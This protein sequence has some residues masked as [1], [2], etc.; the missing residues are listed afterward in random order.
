MGTYAQLIAEARAEEREL[1]TV[2]RREDRAVVTLNEPD[3][4][5]PLSLGLTLQLQDR[6]TEL[7][8]DPAIRAVVLT[9]ADPAFCAGGDIGLIAS[10]SAQI[11]D[12]GS[13]M[14]TPDAWHWIRRHFGGVV[15]VLASAET[16]FI[17]AINGPAA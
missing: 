4:L 14:E 12:A 8:T 15:R 17:A 10:S 5:N 6:L 16:A 7:A 3:R 2:E 11:R 13:D 1:V 9:G